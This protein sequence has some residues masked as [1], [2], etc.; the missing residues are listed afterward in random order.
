[1]R[2]W[3]SLATVLLLILAGCGT[4][5]T[6]STTGKLKVGFIF[7]T[8]LGDPGWTTRQ[9]AGR[10]YLEEKMKGT[11][12]TSYVEN[13]PEG[14]DVERVLTEMARGGHKL[15]VAANFGYMDTVISVAQKFPNVHFLHAT[16]YKTAPNV[17]TYHGR[18]YQAQ[19]LSGMVAGKATRN[20]LIGFVAAVPIPEVVRDINA[21]TLGARAVNPNVKVR[22]VW[23]NT[24]YDPAKEREAANTLIDAGADVI[25]HF[26][27]SAGPLQAAEARGVRAV[28]FH[29]DMSQFA[30]KAFLVASVWNWGPIF[31][32]AAEGVKAG[33]WKSTEIWAS[34]ADGVVDISKFGEGV[35][36]EV[37]DQ[38]TKAREEIKKG[39]LNVFAGPIRDQTGAVKVAQGQA[40]NDGDLLGMMW[41]V[42]GVE[43][44]VPK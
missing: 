1:M 3:V 26:T 38:V 22:V 17:S 25:A 20:N 2:K 10:L 24:W 36:K 29:A 13:V 44:T 32:Q 6:A 34:L 30:P 39:T 19:Y 7:N 9:N 27:N 8:P 11:V 5:P 42:E 21:L 18:M 35:P 12:E 4:K 16:G 33:T 28:G 43:G 31:H 15:V 40:L 14:A 23:V 41:F 37:Q